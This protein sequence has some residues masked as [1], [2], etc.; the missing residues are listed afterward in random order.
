MQFAPMQYGN[1]KGYE[2]SACG[3]YVIAKTRFG[4]LAYVGFGT[5]GQTLLT[6]KHSPNTRA[7][8]V[9]DCNSHATTKGA[10]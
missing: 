1:V 9:G 5:A 3:N 10:Q 2:K 7:G 6:G 4:W 8:A